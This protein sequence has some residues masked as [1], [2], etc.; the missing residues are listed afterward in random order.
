MVLLDTLG[1]D[2]GLFVFPQEAI[3]GAMESFGIKDFQSQ[4]LLLAN[5]AELGAF[6]TCMADRASW[7]LVLSPSLLPSVVYKT[8]TI[9]YTCGYHQGIVDRHP[10]YAFLFTSDCWKLRE[11][12]HSDPIEQLLDDPLT[13]RRRIVESRWRQVEGDPRNQNVFRDVTLLLWYAKAWLIASPER[14][15]IELSGAVRELH[16]R[17]DLPR[18]I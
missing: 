5:Y 13:V 2:T 15:R 9:T 6:I 14:A 1:P 18:P 8:N 12:L 7:P 16:R 4:N 11:I 3:N 17:L 10:E